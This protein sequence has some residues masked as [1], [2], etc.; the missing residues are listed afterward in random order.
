MASISFTDAIGAAVLSNGL[1]A[2]ADRFA[3]WL[4]LYERVGPQRVAGGTGDSYHF[5]LRHDYGARFVL[6]QVPAASL[7]VAVRLKAYLESVDAA[8]ISVATGD[9][10]NRTYATCTLWPGSTVELVLVDPAE[11][12]YDVRLS[13]LDRQTTPGPMRCVY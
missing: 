6:P 8:R 9:S 12:R 3:E 7:D 13:V 1:P 11:Q 10:S 5:P 4:P 2:P